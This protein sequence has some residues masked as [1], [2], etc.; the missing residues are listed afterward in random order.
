VSD[1]PAYRRHRPWSR[2]PLDEAL[3]DT[4]GLGDTVASEQHFLDPL[5]VPAPLL[6][7]VEVAAVRIEW[8]VE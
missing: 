1:E 6:Y 4:L 2:T 8:I 5:S 7:L 3:K